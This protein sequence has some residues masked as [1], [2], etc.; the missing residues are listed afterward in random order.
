MTAQQIRFVKQN[1][2]HAIQ[3]GAK[4]ALNPTVI[5]AQAAI[6]SGW[7]NSRLAK[8]ARNFFG[9][10][11]YGCPNEFWQGKKIQ[12]GTAPHTLPFRLYLNPA[13]SFFDFARL[14]RNRYRM[15]WQ[16]SE[17]LEAYAKEI[18]YS[19]YLSEANGDNREIYRRTMI[20]CGKT[21]QAIV[22]L[23]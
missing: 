12:A 9:L 14:I 15:A 5:L 18:A 16:M 17:D 22:Q 8:E 4:F 10:T 1:L 7:G 21:I 11:A 20:A 13:N 2:P 23:L 3:A 6:E 19:A